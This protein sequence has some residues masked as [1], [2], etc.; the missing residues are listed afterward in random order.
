VLSE[1]L[2]L[3]ITFLCIMEVFPTD[4]INAGRL[5]AVVIENMPERF[6]NPL[7]FTQEMIQVAKPMFLVCLCFAS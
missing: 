4:P 5:R 3:K 1:F 7:S 2:I 6:L